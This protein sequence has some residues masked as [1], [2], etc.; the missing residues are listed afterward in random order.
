MLLDD[1]KICPTVLNC[2]CVTIY[3]REMAMELDALNQTRREIE[4]GMKEEV[5]AYC[6]RL[7]F[8]DDQAL[9]SGI[10]L[11]QAGLAPRRDRDFSVTDK[12]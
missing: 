1:W 6:E 4:Q 2:Y 5:I 11:Y 9:L 10:A 8:T 3:R 7:Q 12:R